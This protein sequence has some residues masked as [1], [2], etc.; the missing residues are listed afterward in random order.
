MINFLDTVFGEVGKGGKEL[1]KDDVKLRIARYGLV[2]AIVV[3]LIGGTFQLLKINMQLKQQKHMIEQKDAMQKYLLITEKFNKKERRFGKAS[4]LILNDA[5]SVQFDDMKIVVLTQHYQKNK[6]PK[7]EF[8]NKKHKLEI[9]Q[10]ADNLKFIRDERIYREVIG[11]KVYKTAGKFANW[12]DNIID[13]SKL[14]AAPTYH[15]LINSIDKI[16]ASIMKMNGT[17]EQEYNKI[18]KKGP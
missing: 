1:T 2:V 13:F 8:L 3:A 6:G 12:N 16:Q 15:F 17:Y 7:K 5:I 18:I 9:L 4:D 10:E 14:Q 11:K